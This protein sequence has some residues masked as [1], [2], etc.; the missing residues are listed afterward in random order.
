MSEP[1]PHRPPRRKLSE[2]LRS[3]TRR[4]GVE[5]EGFRVGLKPEK[6]WAKRNYE[7]FSRSLIPTMLRKRQAA[8]FEDAPEFGDVH[9]NE[10]EIV[11]IGH[12]SF[13]VRSPGH[14]ILIDPNW[15]LWMGPVKRMREPGLKVEQ[16]PEIDLILI[17]HAHFDHLH[18]PSL[19][20][21]ARGQTVLVPKGVS[22]VLKGLDFGEVHEL[23]VW[24]HHRHGDIE[25]VFTPSY[26]WGARFIADTHRGFG[27][28][29]LRNDHTSLYHCGDSAYFEGFTDIGQR[30]RIDT[31]ILPI[32]AYD[33]PSGREVHM[34]PEEALRAFE[35]LGAAR[36]IP[37]HHETFPLG[38]GKPCEPLRR[39][40]A[41]AE[42]KN[43]AERVL[44]P[45]EG[46]KV[47]L[48][49]P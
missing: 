46:E 3:F 24:D 37:M 7:F 42:S 11:W 21:V 40:T 36:M 1:P 49:K 34:N 27:G 14:N 17:S 33:C 2:R 39:L 20:R 5:T 16:L 32:G 10:F 19:K 9:F 38:I 35:D 15:A 23:D 45:R 30:Y 28:F 13:L 12:A 29:I 26:H 22:G 4:N 6:G 43:L 44:S 41:A 18:R 8:H 25:V 31:A 48:R 47:T